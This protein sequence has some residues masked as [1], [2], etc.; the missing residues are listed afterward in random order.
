MNTLLN[1]QII[2]LH[3]ARSGTELLFT[4]LCHEEQG[5]RDRAVLEKYVSDVSTNALVV[6]LTVC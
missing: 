3:A 6:K 1:K 5:R 2:A 4:A